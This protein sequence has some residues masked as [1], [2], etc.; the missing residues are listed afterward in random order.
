MSSA[1]RVAPLSSLPAAGASLTGSRAALVPIAAPP[2]RHLRGRGPGELALAATL[3]SLYAG[4]RGA[5]GLLGVIEGVVH[6]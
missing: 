6:R 5:A 1:V 3:L 4:V 2:R